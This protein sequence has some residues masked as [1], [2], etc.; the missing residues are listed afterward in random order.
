MVCYRMSGASWNRKPLLVVSEISGED[1]SWR[2]PEKL[3]V[4]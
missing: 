1:V 2:R 3:G 4:C